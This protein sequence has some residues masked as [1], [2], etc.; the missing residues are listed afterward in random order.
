MAQPQTRG[1][2]MTHNNQKVLGMGYPF[3]KLSYSKPQINDGVTGFV[4]GLSH[5]LAA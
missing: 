5:L 4:W 1:R 2:E 3:N